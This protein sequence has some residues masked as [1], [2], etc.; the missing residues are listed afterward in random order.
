MV[1]Q[2]PHGIDMH[3][4]NLR[5]ALTPDD[6]IFVVALPETLAAVNSVSDDRVTLVPFVPA[7]K[8]PRGILNFWREFPTLLRRYRIEAEWFLFMQQDIWFFRPPEPQADPKRIRSF[9]PWN[10]YHNIM[11]GERMLHPRVWEGAQL[12][13][14]TLVRR[15]LDAGIDFSF[16]KETFLDRR[17]PEFEAEV[18]APVSISDFGKPDT[19]DEFGLHCA[20][21]ERTTLEFDVRAAHL[22]GPEVLHRRFPEIYRGA[23]RQALAGVQQQV[24]YMDTL[25]AVAMYYIAGLWDE[26]DHLDWTGIRPG[27]ELL[28]DDLL[29][30]APRW[31]RPD[32]LA[33]LQRVRRLMRGGELPRQRDFA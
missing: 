18:G 17:R 3:V 23:T 11:A 30:S 27:G 5:W 20:L 8:R 25:L 4:R 22:R 9:L 16:V 14:N 33:R 26:I 6:H 2:F 28:I 13:H 31:M 32:E 7:E 19:M 12:I 24:Q 21:V 10:Y 15:A 29:E 1:G